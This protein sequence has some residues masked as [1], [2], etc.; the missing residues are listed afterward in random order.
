MRH[1]LAA[2]LMSAV[3][4]AAEPSANLL[5]DADFEAAETTAW[6]KRTPDGPDR[7]LAIVAAAA[8]SGQRLARIVNRHPTV[9]RWR[10]GADA[11]LR[12]EPGSVVRL[13]GW[14]RTEIG[15]E[16]YA[17]LRLYCMG[18]GGE[19]LIQP[20][21]RALAGKSEWKRQSL[22]A[23]VPRETDHL[24]VYLELQNAI[25]LAEFD[26]VSLSVIAPPEPRVARNDLVLLTDAARDD[27]TVRSLTALYPERLVLCST[28]TRPELEKYRGA[29]VFSRNPETTFDFDAIEKLAAAGRPVVVDLGA[30]ARWRAL[31]VRELTATNQ[32]TMHILAQHPATRGFQVADSIPWGARKDETWAQRVLRGKTCGQILAESSAGDGALLVAESLGKGTIL[33]TDLCAL[34]EPAY[35]V[36]GSFNKY[37]FAGSIIGGSVRYGRHFARKLTYADFVDAMRA[38]A[39]ELPALRF[40]DEGPANGGARICSLNLGEPQKPALL[41]YAATHGSEWEPAYGLLALARLLAAGPTRALLDTDRYCLKLIPI[42][43]PTG[44]DLNTRQSAARVDLNRNGG[45]W[46]DAFRGRDSNKDG[47]Y[48]P[49]DYDWKGPGPFSEAETQTLRS[50]CER[51]KLYATL[52]FHGN[53]GGRGNNRLVVMPL[54]ARDDNE[55][56]VDAAVRAFNAAIRD[57]Y[58]FLEA[59]RPAVEQYEIEAVQMDSQRPTL[60]Q[61]ASKGRYGFLCEVPAGYPGTYGLVTQTDIVIETCLAFFGAYRQ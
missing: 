19:I 12:V 16:G 11:T 28:M 30:Y 18:K 45:E 60:I 27:P 44:Y 61:T 13:A 39:A 24:M 40:E 5:R 21:T 46:W 33:A 31:E 42:L 4:C 3:A 56:R 29:I 43:N 51:L 54:T 35:N 41:I 1:I 2:L 23:T 20:Q 14:I 8:H 36:P 59:S 55:E 32:P 17:S 57:R 25:G 9:S 47:A 34:P 50:V 52:D 15:A 38:L 22:T 37:L 6:E 49:G 48:G 26:D 7:E 10:Q 53:A 58:V